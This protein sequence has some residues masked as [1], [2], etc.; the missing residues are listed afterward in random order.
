M[1][2]RK[3]FSALLSFVEKFYGKYHT[4]RLYTI[5]ETAKKKVAAA[6]S[7]YP[8]FHSVKCAITVY[9]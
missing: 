6:S 7:S 4:H 2:F 3:K 5:E 1:Q 8:F 9:F